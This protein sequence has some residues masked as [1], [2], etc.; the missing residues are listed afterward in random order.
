MVNVLLL[1]MALKNTSIFYIIYNFDATFHNL[2]L[3]IQYVTLKFHENT[4]AK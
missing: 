3:Q 4:E 1:Y 2:L